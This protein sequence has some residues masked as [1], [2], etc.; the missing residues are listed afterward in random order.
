MGDERAMGPPSSGRCPVDQVSVKLDCPVTVGGEAAS[1]DAKEV[2]PAEATRPPRR[3]RWGGWPLRADEAGRRLPE[4]AR[5]VAGPGP[6]AARA[7]VGTPAVR[8]RC[9]SDPRNFDRHRVVRRPV[10][11]GQ[12][13]LA[14]APNRR[15]GAP[16]TTRTRNLVGR[17]H[18]LYPVELQ[19]PAAVKDTATVRTAIG[20]CHTRG[21]LVAVAQLA[22][23]RDVAPEVAGSSPVGHPLAPG[24]P[25]ATE[26]ARGSTVVRRR[27]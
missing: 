27:L 11:S 23:R 26:Y 9:A 3:G 7:P 5:R 6:D 18:L 21:S 14:A 19:G 13:G 24:E 4:H 8:A 1:P 15:S 20:L 10:A 17:N 22:E 12:R 25:R 2:E 16:G